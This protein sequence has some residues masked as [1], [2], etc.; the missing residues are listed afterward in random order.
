VS[1]YALNTWLNPVTNAYERCFGLTEK[2]VVWEVGSR[3]GRDGVELASRIYLGQQPWFWTN[4]VVVAV[5]PNPDQAKIIRENYPEVEVLEIAASNVKGEAPFMVYEGDEGAVGCSSLNLRWKE[6]DLPG[7][8]ITVETDR[9]DNIIG[10][11]QIDI[12]KIDVEGHS[13]EVIEGLGDKLRNVKVYHIETEKWTDS[14]IK[15][16]AFMMGH[17]YTLMDETEQ[18]GGMPDQVWVRG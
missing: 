11:Q 10:D 6:D 13:I 9:L 8:E 14:N 3:D 16:K 7:H 17:G 2:P 1:D 12:M 15:M 18:Y 5:E 4:A